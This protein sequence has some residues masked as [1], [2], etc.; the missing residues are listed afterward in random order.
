MSSKFYNNYYWGISKISNDFYSWQYF[1]YKKYILPILNNFNKD[2]SNI[3]V[4]EIW[5]GPGYFANFCSLVGISKFTW[6]DLDSQIIVDTSIKFPKYTFLCSDGIDFLKNYKWEGF[7]IIFLSHVFEHLNDQQSIEMIKC[8]EEHLWGKWVWI[9]IMPN[10]ASL[11]SGFLR[12]HD[13]THYKLYTDNSMNQ[14]INSVSPDIFNISHS[15]IYP[16]FLKT[17][18]RYIFPII[19]FLRKMVLLSLGWYYHIYTNEI[20][21]I[22]KRKS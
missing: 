17:F 1:R 8:I 4:L 14:L 20:I 19:L 5:S 18:H 11:N 10:A 13:Y 15:N 16:V 6:I 7:D 3:S 2:I 21:S 12:Y 22:I 9:N